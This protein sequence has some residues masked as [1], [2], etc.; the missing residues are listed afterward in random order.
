MKKFP[1]AML[2]AAILC[3]VAAGCGAS[4]QE[5]S[6]MPLT[7]PS[8][9]ITQKP[10]HGSFAGGG[11]GSVGS[12]PVA[13]ESP[14]SLRIVY[15]QDTPNSIT[16]ISSMEQLRTYGLYGS[17][18]LAA[19][20]EDFFASKALVLVK[21]TVNSGST[22]LQFGDAIR[23]SNMVSVSME[24]QPADFGTSD[25]ATW[26]L[27]AEVDPSLRDCQWVLDTAQINSGGIAY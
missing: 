27:W 7:S 26:L 23:V 4:K 5:E 20:D 6:T 12:T 16:Y 9:A 10:S 1:L 25:M 17:E 22:K 2:L 19:Y 21:Y 3:T 14:Q 24:A 13:L 15:Q 8:A 18:K 11:T